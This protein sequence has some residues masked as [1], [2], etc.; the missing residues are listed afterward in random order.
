MWG[1]VRVVGWGGVGW[2]RDW[3]QAGACRCAHIHTNTHAQSAS[4]SIAEGSGRQQR[5]ARG[6]LCRP[7]L[8]SQVRQQAGGAEV[9]ALR[10]AVVL[11]YIEAGGGQLRGGR[12]GRG[13]EGREVEG[14]LMESPWGK[15]HDVALR[16]R[17]R[18]R[19][20]D[21]AQPKGATA[22]PCACGSALPGT[23][24]GQCQSTV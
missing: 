24:W 4:L 21:V 1:R 23:P 2:G 18:S 16:T 19:P 10:R 3:R 22:E 5:A 20:F 17:R 7:C 8:Q 15:Q 14:P 13:G 12:G 6:V 11:K 9:G